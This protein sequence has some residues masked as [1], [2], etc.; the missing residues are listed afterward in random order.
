MFQLMSVPEQLDFVENALHTMDRGQIGQVDRIIRPLLLRDFIAHLPGMFSDFFLII[1]CR[2][3][4]CMY[5]K[6]S[7][8]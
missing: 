3:F 6:I 5:F 4:A 1:T 2:R 8:C 7:G